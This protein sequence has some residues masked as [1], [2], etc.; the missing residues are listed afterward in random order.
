MAE[1][2]L[3]RLARAP[4]QAA[5]WLVVDGSG[6]P[7][8]PPQS[9][10]L[11]LAAPRAATRRVCVL[12]PGTDVLLAQPD[13]PLKAGAKLA[14]LVPYALEEHLADA[15]EDLHFALGKRQGDA[16]RT[17]VAVVARRLM[18]EWLAQLRAAGIEPNALYAD[19]DLLPLNP[20]QAVALLEEDAVF[21]RPP[22][23]T[24]VTLPADAL[25]QALQIAHASA[26]SAASGGS[27]LILYT[28]AAEW[29]RHAAQVE[30][31]RP[32]FDGIKVQLLTDGPLALFAQ[33]L[34]RETAIN[35]LQADYAP[36]SGRGA[37]L[38]AWRVAAM[39]LAA[40]LVL[41]IGGK[42]IQLRVLKS[43]EHTVDAS[44]RDVAHSV[45]ETSLLD[46]R[47]H[48]EARVA[49]ARG[50]G[51][52]L[53]PALQ[54]LAQARTST[55]GTSVRELNFHGGSLEMTLGARDAA[56]L[57]HLSQTLRENGWT[58]E[59]GSG[60]NTADGYL[61]RIQVHANGT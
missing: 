29:Q 22:H 38:R 25:D 14:T 11:T 24:P 50:A 8:G 56:S 54:A 34:P 46:V 43:R 7:T 60:S 13:L 4:D 45:G 5:T 28:G 58:A 30:A 61:G 6:A 19:S 51:G 36:A 1:T 15:I 47:K 49:A 23:G 27:G 57:A 52:G 42:V 20:G 9:G 40:L 18:D 39:L 37:H 59:L 16:T 44:I 35:L 17:R 21:V 55:P 53:L 10:P 31:V 48:L 32:S 33:Q 2:L 12:V 41:H 3:L 26:D